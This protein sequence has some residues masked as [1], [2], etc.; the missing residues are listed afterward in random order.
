MVGFGLGVGF[1]PFFRKDSLILKMWTAFQFSQ[2]YH[3]SFNRR[4]LILCKW[5][6][7]YNTYLLLEFLFVIQHDTEAEIICWLHQQELFI[8]F[9]IT[10]K[11]TEQVSDQE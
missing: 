3:L 1:Y 7:M 6:W 9:Q 8:Y 10:S 4:A 2:V 11:D 5:A